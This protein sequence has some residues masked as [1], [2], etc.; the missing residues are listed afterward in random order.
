MPAA[1]LGPADVRKLVDRGGAGANVGH[2]FGSLSR[3]L[4]WC[5][6]TGQLR[7]GSLRSDRPF[8]TSQG[9]PSPA[10]VL[11]AAD[12]ARLWK[13]A[14]IWASRSGATLS[15]SSLRYPAGARRRP[16]LTGHMLISRRPE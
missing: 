7:G 15:G 13:V 14:D 8:T 11:A 16:T 10:H 6:E 2:R 1:D 3:F 9:V 5:Q 4:D 12:L